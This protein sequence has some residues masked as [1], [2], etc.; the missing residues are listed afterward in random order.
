M[1]LSNPVVCALLQHAS[2]NKYLV[3]LRSY[4]AVVK[5]FHG[6]RVFIV[7]DNPS[8]LIYNGVFE[9]DCIITQ[10]DFKRLFAKKQGAL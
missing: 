10:E 4:C 8:P 9:T 2:N 3:E 5:D 6:K 1:N 7:D